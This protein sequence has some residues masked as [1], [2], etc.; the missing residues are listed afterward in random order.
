MVQRLHP[1]IPPHRPATRPRFAR[2]A[3]RTDLSRGAD[4]VPGDRGSAE[5][6]ERVKRKLISEL[7][8]STDTNEIDEVRHRLKN[9]FDQ[10][11]EAENLVLT[12]AEKERLFE[13]LRPTSS[14]RSDRAFAHRSHRYRDH[15]QWPQ[16]DLLRA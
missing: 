1:R 16:E 11:I 6:Q 13:S 5:P 14:L 7:D 3:D 12:R 10:I 15:G 8:P 2:R 4:P 9:L